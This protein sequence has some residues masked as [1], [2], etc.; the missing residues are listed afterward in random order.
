MEVV[1][2]RSAFL[3]TYIVWAIF[4]LTNLSLLFPFIIPVFLPFLLVF[5]AKFLNFLAPVFALA[6]LIAIIAFPYVYEKL[7]NE[8]KVFSPLIF[9]II[10]IMLF[11]TI[12]EIYKCIL[13]AKELYIIK[14]E[15]TSSQPFIGSLAS[16]GEFSPEHAYYIKNKRIYFWSYSELKYVAGSDE[17]FRTYKSDIEA[18]CS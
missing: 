13:I 18:S 16:Q 14:P 17:S 9:N 7:N 10:F 5:S 8:V 12:A 15:C 2:Y 6:L 1:N 3:Q 11:L 4:S